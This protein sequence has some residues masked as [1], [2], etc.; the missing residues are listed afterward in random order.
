ME[1][2]KNTFGDFAT[3]ISI[4]GIAFYILGW[5]YWN[6]FYKAL[7]ISLSFFDLSFD[8][9]I[10]TTWPF[11]L[12]SIAGFIPTFVQISGE[13]NKSWD[14]ITVIYVIVN[15]LFLS[16]FYLLKFDYFVIPFLI[17]SSIYILTRIIIRW[18]EIEVKYI[19]V[20]SIRFAI[21]AAIYAFGLFLYGY[22]GRKDA[23]K[24]IENYQE[25][26]RIVL[27][28]NNEIFGRFITNNNGKT[29]IIT[30]LNN[31]KKEIVIIN[32]EEILKIVTSVK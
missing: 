32:D 14:I 22:S 30:E 13:K 24:L 21:I 7:N 19:S 31:C 3:W 16:F 8:K 26:F 10:I 2:K 6:C 1:E 9:V 18:K 25:D 5:I 23:L 17:F 29:F 15:A 20:Q 28:N 11:I 12:L 27:K 4:C